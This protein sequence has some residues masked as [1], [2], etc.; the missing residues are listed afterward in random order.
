MK[1]K[2]THIKQVENENK[3]H[4]HEGRKKY[5]LHLFEAVDSVY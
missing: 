1:E 3:F 2:K 4:L 5:L